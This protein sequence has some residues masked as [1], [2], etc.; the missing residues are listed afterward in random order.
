MEMVYAPARRA[1]EAAL[2]VAD[3][4]VHVA[5]LEHLPRRGPAVL[6]ANHVSYLDPVLVAWATTRLRPAR[7]PRFL[8]KSELF[9]GRLVGR[10]LHGMRHVPVDRERSPARALVEGTRRLSEGDLVA[11]FPEGT[12]SRALMP[13]RLKPGAARMAMRAGAPLLPV[14][15]WGGHR[16]WPEGRL[17]LQRGVPLVTLVGAPVTYDAHE[18]PAAVTARLEEALTELVEAAQR[19]Y[20]ERPRTVEELWWLPRYLGGTAMSVAEAEALAAREAGERRAQRPATA[21]AQRPAAA[22]AQRAA[23]TPA[24]RQASMVRARAARAARVGRRAAARRAVRLGRRK[25]TTTQRTIR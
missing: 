20:P 8:A 12:T 19:A 18:H 22:S 9:E 5:G 4:P 15:V 25:R 2:A 1:V 17:R 7:Y 6:A 10:L 14:A 13:T 24:K 16:V 11:L 3:W 21:P 23:A